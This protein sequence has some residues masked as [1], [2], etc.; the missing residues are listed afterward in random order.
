MT[1]YLRF[2]DNLYFNEDIQKTTFGC[3]KI[4]MA[5]AGIVSPGDC[6]ESRFNCIWLCKNTAVG[7]KNNQQKEECIDSINLYFLNNALQ[8]CYDSL[9]IISYFISE[10]KKSLKIS[11][12]RLKL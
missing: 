9:H 4:R 11:Y 12:S 2:Y 5:R 3:F 8:Y 1:A 6:E 7:M 10:W